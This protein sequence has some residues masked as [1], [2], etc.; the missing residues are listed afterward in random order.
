MQWGLSSYLTGLTNLAS[1]ISKE[2]GPS[3]IDVDC[4]DKDNYEEAFAKRYNISKD[5]IELKEEDMSLEQILKA[6]LGESNKEL[7]ESLLY[8]IEFKVG[9]SIKVYT[10]KNNKLIDAL[11]RCEGGISMFYIVDDIYFV[12]FDE[13]MVCF[14]LGN[15][16]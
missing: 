9:K 5:L 13:Y 12:E 7:I 15:N 11:S 8:W 10:E 1:S 6:W 16:E 4:M 14:S 3:F 2:I